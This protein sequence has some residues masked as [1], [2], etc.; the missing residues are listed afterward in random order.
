MRIADFGLPTADRQRL[1]VVERSRNATIR[2]YDRTTVRPVNS[3]GDLKSPPELTVQDH[4]TLRPCD[5]CRSLSRVET[6]PCETLRRGLDRSIHR[7]A[8]PL[9]ASPG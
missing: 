7:Q 6:R 4:A 3:G 5:P 1:P 9:V 2:L 8:R